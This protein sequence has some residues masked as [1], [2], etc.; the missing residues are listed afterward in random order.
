LL[1][2]IYQLL[3]PKHYFQAI[4]SILILALAV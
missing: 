3:E 2:T 1:Y 4:S